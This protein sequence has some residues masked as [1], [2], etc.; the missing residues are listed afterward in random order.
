MVKQG[1]VNQDIADLLKVHS[2][3]I[4]N[5]FHNRGNSDFS[6][7]EAYLIRDTYFKNQSLEELFK[8]E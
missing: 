6:I 1:L 5:K 7:K 8:R 4:G 2:T 3:T